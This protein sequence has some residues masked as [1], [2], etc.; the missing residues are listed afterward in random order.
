MAQALAPARVT[1][2]TTVLGPAACAPRSLERLAASVL[3][4]GLPNVLVADDPLVDDLVE[5]GVGGVLLNGTNVVSEDQVRDLVSGL[6]ERFD[7]HLTIA[8]DEEGGRVSPLSEIGLGGSSAR[9]LARRDEDDVEAAGREAGAVAADLG[10]TLLLGPVAD[11][12]DGPFD[13]IIGDR[14]FGADPEQVGEAA[15]RY[16]EG[17][18]QAGVDTAV[19][20][21]PGYAEAPDTHLGGGTAAVDHDEL[22]ERHVAAFLPLLDD[23]VPAVMVSHVVYPSLGPL[24]ASLNPASYRLLRAT[25]YEGPALTDALGMG[26]IHTRWGFDRSAAMA[27]AA[28]ADVALSN[29]G[30]EADL[31]RDGIVT[32][33]RSGS[34]S[35]RRLRQAA[36]R[37]ATLRPG[38]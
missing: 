34:L 18:G 12:D 35:E 27:V 3:L 24:P 15:R 23:G 26:A 28:G 31:L 4:V 1:A 30:E 10:V 8:L 36:E 2:P 6:A 11:L 32:A 9:R 5:L 19:K 20:H 38:C 13:G 16:A 17:V 22:V 29:Q 33:V 7:G 21:W 37:A 25:G 14:S